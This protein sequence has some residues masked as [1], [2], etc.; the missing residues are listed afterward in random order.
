VR[1]VVRSGGT[2]IASAP[3]RIGRLPPFG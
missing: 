3:I 2:E 1:A